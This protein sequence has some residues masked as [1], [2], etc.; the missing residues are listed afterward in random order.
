MMIP[1][2]MPVADARANLSEVLN[3][4]RLQDRTVL[5]LRRGTEQAGIVPPDILKLINAVGLPGARDALVG[6]RAEIEAAS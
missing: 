1:S 2:E 5:L 6:L 3:S 4:V